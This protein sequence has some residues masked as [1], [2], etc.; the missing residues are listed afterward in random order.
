M[1]LFV[2]H[3]VAM[4]Q[5][6]SL[7]FHAPTGRL[8]VGV[9]D[10]GVQLWRTHSAPSS[11]SSSTTAIAPS[12]PSSSSTIRFATLRADLAEAERKLAETKATI[13]TETQKCG[14]AA[15]QKERLTAD[16][17][18]LRAERAPYIVIIACDSQSD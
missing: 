3:C 1:L 16:I 18:R 4:W 10:V 6:Y 5:I 17:A 9:Y 2:T 8:A 7:S 15:A 12:L 11:S 13:A 14:P